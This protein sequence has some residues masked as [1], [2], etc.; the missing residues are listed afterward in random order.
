M[1]RA[2]FNRKNN[3]Q[4]NDNLRLI[5]DALPLQ[6]K[7]SWEM[8]AEEAVEATGQ[9]QD[10]GNTMGRNEKRQLQRAAGCDRAV[11]MLG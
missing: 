3:K 11:E 6:P 10:E 7:D 2:T 5:V 1:Q 8:S 9:P 4:L